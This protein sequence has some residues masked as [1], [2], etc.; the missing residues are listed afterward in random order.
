VKVRIGLCVACVAL[1]GLLL[2][3][4]PPKGEG[5]KPSPDPVIYAKA[6][7][8]G[9]LVG[10]HEDWEPMYIIVASRPKAAKLPLIVSELQRWSKER[11]EK[12]HGKPV[13]VSGILERKTFGTKT[14]GKEDHL[15]LVAKTMDSVVWENGGQPPKDEPFYAKVEARGILRGLP[16]DE[17]PMNI[18]ISPNPKWLPLPLITDKLEEW[19]E[20]RWKKANLGYIRVGGTLEFMPVKTRP[21]FINDGFVL[22]AKNLDVV[23]DD[24][25]FKD[26]P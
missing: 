26:L 5:G 18:V 8:R 23:E 3:A 14:G 6:E 24:E 21:G 12:M 7:V 17:E 2:R 9:E 13:R 10:K 15:A 25:P 16:F 20:E 22:V 4:D 11:F 19:P 1:A